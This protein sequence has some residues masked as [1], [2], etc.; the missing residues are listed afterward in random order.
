[1]DGVAKCMPPPFCGQ[2]TGGTGCEGYAGGKYC[3]HCGGSSCCTHGINTPTAPNCCPS[4]DASCVDGTPLCTP[5]YACGGGSENTPAQCLGNGCSNISCWLPS[6]LK[7]GMACPA[8]P[9]P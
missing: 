2:G 4:G 5:G 9:G 1:V 3:G 8:G 6:D 7:L